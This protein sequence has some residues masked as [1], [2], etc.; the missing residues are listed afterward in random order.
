MKKHWSYFLLAFLAPVLAVLWWWGLFA[1]VTTEIGEYGGYR[2]AYLEA[3]GPYSKL[4]KLQN[5]AFALLQ[6]QGIDAGAQITL[7]FSDPRTTPA[8]A[9]HARTGFIIGA[10]ATPADPLKVAAVPVRQALM[11][12]IKAH[13]LFAYGKVYSVLLEFAKRQH[14]QL[15]LPTVEIVKSSVLHVEMPLHDADAE[16]ASQ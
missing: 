10:D 4:N 9:L 3:T 6:Q 13:P 7:I 5:E 15:H 14:T 1:S 8:D 12:E 2:Y 11:A 16:H